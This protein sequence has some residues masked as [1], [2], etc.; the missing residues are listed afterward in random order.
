MMGGSCSHYPAV[1]GMSDDIIKM[2]VL[3][4]LKTIKGHLSG[5]EKM[6]EDGKSCEEIL[7]QIAAVRSSVE[8]TG[9][10]LL[11]EHAVE[12][13]VEDIASKESKEKLERIISTI[14]KFMK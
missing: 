3:N 13:L 2:E 10:M 14:I 4:R 6:V 1:A 7:L 9:L 8:K 5:I 11:E 12:C